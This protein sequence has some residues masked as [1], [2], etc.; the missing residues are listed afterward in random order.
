MA[1]IALPQGDDEEDTSA[2]PPCSNKQYD[3]WCCYCDF[4]W[5]NSKTGYK[6]RLY[7]L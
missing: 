6:A 3:A 1:V 4:L 5:S 2:A 7:D